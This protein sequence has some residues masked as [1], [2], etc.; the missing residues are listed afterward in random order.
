MKRYSIWIAAAVLLVVG[1]MAVFMR[2]VG[3]DPAVWHVDPATA[4]RSGKPNDYMVAPD[5]AIAAQADQSTTVR[6]LPAK[7]H[8]FLFDA[9][10]MNAPRTEIIG[11]SLDEGWITY[12]QRSMLFGYPDYITVKAVEVEGGSAL[13]VWSRARY[14]YGDMGV[15]RDRVERWLAQ[16]GEGQS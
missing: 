2:V 16:I 11:G 14:G 12:V 3:D 1:A 8:L 13:I 6:D 15:N 7:E 4:E 10:A 5:G 9:V